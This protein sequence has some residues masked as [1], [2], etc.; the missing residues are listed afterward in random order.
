MLPQITISIAFSAGLLSFFSPCLLPVIPGFIAY[1]TGVTHAEHQQLSKRLHS[2][3]HGICFVLGF[4]LIYIALGWSASSVGSIFFEHDVWLR[5][6]GA[7]FIGTMGLAMLEVIQIPILN[8]EFRLPVRL[9]RFRSL[10]SFLVGLTF[11]LGWSPCIGPIMA[12]IL[13]LAGTDPQHG[14][15]L[16]AAFS[17]GFAVPFL[18]TAYAFPSWRSFNKFTPV[19]RR[20]GGA[21]LIVTA[22]LL[23][24]DMLRELAIYFVTVSGYIGI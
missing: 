11:A 3:V 17:F 22:V 4:S 18:V 21:L 9:R 15:Y 23:W 7:L 5:R 12:S 8:R 20:V 6:A 10:G 19:L 13:F 2:L 16:M 14:V 1:V 24:L